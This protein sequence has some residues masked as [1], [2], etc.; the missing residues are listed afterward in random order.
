MAQVAISTRLSE[1]LQIRHPVIC[2]PMDGIAGGKLAAA[3]SSAGGLGL[4]GGGYSD[5]EA[6]FEREFSAAGNQRIGCGFITWALRRK[7]GR[8]DP[9]MH[10]SGGRTDFGQGTDDRRCWLMTEAATFTPAATAI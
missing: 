1:R 4:Q 2:A 8:C 6:W 9:R 10:G 7:P 5:E 3:V